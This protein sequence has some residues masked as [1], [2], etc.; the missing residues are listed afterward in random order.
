METM[1]SDLN[2]IFVLA[3]PEEQIVDALSKSNKFL[4]EGGKC[5]MCIVQNQGPNG[6]KCI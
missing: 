3:A 1:L 6:E 5:K 2:T 4:K